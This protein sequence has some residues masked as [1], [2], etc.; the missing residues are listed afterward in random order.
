MDESNQQKKR[1]ISI[2]INNLEEIII[3]RLNTLS[4][5]QWALLSHGIRDS[6]ISKVLTD[7]LSDIFQ[8]C[9]ERALMVLLQEMEE[10]VEENAM[11]EMP[12][13]AISVHL[14]N[15]IS[16][17]MAKALDV[18]TE[19]C[20]SGMEL[21]SLMEEELSQKMTSIVKSIRETPELPTE[22]VVFAG[23]L[24]S[25]LRN[26]NRMISNEVQCLRPNINKYGSRCAKCWSIFTKKRISGLLSKPKTDIKISEERISPS[27]QAHYDVESLSETITEVIEKYSD[28]FKDANNDSQSFQ[29]LDPFET[30]EVADQIS[31]TIVKDLHHCKS[32]GSVEKKCQDCSCA[33]H[34]NLTKIVNNVKNL[35][36]S[37]GSFTK[38]EIF[39]K[40]EFSRFVEQQFTS[41]VRNLEKSIASNN[42]HV[43]KL[44][45]DQGKL[46]TWPCVMLFGCVSDNTPEEN[47][48]KILDFDKMDRISEQDLESIKHQINCLF[49]EDEE[50]PHLND[51]IKQFTKEL[52]DKLYVNIMRSQYYTFPVPPKGKFLS[53]SVLSGM[54]IRDISGQEEICPEIFYARTEDE[55]GRFLQNIFVWVQNEKPAHLSDH[56][57]VSGVL[58]EIDDLV[59]KIYE[60]SSQSPQ[61]LPSESKMETDNTTTVLNERFEQPFYKPLYRGTDEEDHISFIP[62]TDSLVVARRHFMRKSPPIDQLITEIEGQ[63]HRDTEVMGCFV[64]RAV[65]DCWKENGGPLNSNQMKIVLYY[66]TGEKTDNIKDLDISVDN[67]NFR[68][69]VDKLYNDLK[70]HFGSAEEVW[71][72]ATSKSGHRF[73]S[74]ILAHIKTYIPSPP[75][76]CLFLRCCSRIRKSLRNLFRKQT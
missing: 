44:K 1:N 63:R 54:K 41:M 59:E 21:N 34:F 27:I 33:P 16:T 72:A 9:L 22:P 71:K 14:T 43:V 73:K 57:R 30:V 42:S 17:E 11:T 67:V 47:H 3:P 13:E 60:T 20:K 37:T 55:V 25:N 39:N 36:R 51:M 4:P 23:G 18:S 62:H 61:V 76:K 45:Q 53:D 24:F 49:A 74:A 58:T 15:W 32:D 52:T 40:P 65:L 12:S 8:Q 66:M 64:S 31:Q 28:D 70:I 75:K 19:I 48:L 2:S 35:F 69:F 26:L 50:N 38:Q 6:H 56:D 68:Q 46:K 7:I 10:R 29:G 5:A